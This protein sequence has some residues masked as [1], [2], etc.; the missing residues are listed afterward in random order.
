M[1]TTNHPQ[2]NLTT[3]EHGER[4]ETLIRNST[5]PLSLGDI[6][7]KLGITGERVRQIC[8]QL[9][10]ERPS[11]TR[12]RKKVRIAKPCPTCGEDLPFKKR[13]RQH[14]LRC[15]TCDPTH[16]TAHCRWCEKTFVLLASE[17]KARNRV[18]LGYKGNIYCSKACLSK[19]QATKKWWETSPIYQLTQEN[20]DMNVRQAIEDY[21]KHQS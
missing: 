17:Y 19:H 3:I 20:D 1:D 5:E 2:P 14:L 12:G 18:H 10:I 4:I 15:P 8:S 7:E 13:R 16:I 11:A 6:G 9:G 21:Q